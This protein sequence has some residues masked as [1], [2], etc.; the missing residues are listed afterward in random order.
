M[1]EGWLNDQQ[2]CSPRAVAVGEVVFESG[3]KK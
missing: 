2:D 1:V 3:R